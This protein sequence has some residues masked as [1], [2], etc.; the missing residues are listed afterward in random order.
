MY[1]IL[2]ITLH[3]QDLSLENR[4]TLLSE[5]SEVLPAIFR[6]ETELVP[7]LVKAPLS[8]ERE[9]PQE[10]QAYHRTFMGKACFKEFHEG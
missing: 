2:L 9:Q 8:S 1:K 4:K 5:I 6:Q 7:Q 10:V 3:S